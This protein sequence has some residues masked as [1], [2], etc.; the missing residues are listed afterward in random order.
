MADYITRAAIEGLVPPKDLLRA[1]DDN[2]DGV[3]DAGLFDALA[4]LA[5]DEVNGLISGAVDVPITEDQPAL[6]KHAA[7]VFLCR[8]LY[9]RAGV[10]LD[11]NPWARQSDALRERLNRIG[12]GEDFLERTAAPAGSVEDVETILSADQQEGL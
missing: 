2:A 3:E 9:D 7:R 11:A 10:A 4:G 8:L 6:L 1:L 12:R 5:E